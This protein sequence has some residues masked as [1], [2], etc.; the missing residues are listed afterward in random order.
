MLELTVV[1]FHGF[2]WA[3]VYCIGARSTDSFYAHRNINTLTAVYGNHIKFHS[4]SCR[5]LK[6]D[7]HSLKIF[8]RRFARAALTPQEGE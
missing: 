1:L 5:D 8:V 4:G 7:T 3:P 2:V 6:H